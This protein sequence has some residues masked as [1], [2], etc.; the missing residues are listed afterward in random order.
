MVTKRQRTWTGKTGAGYLAGGL[1]AGL[2][3]GAVPAT[4]K[5]DVK[6]IPDEYEATS[7]SGVA[8]NDAG[9]AANDAFSAIRANPALM[10]AQKQYEMTGSYHWPT[11]GRDFYQAGVVDSKTAPVA[12]G[13]SYTGFTDDYQYVRSGGTT[14]DASPYDS[15]LIRRICGALAG[16]LGQVMVGAGATYVEA[17]P[18]LG[19]AAYQ[20]GESRVKGFGLNLGLA[21][22]LAPGWSFGAAAENASN[23]KLADYLPRTYKLGIAWQAEPGLTVFLDARQRERVA[24]FEADLPDLDQPAPTSKLMQNPER[25]VIASVSYQAQEYLRLVGSYGKSVTDDRQLAAGGAVL[26]NKQFSLSYTVQ[27][28]YMKQSTAHQAVALSVEMSM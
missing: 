9:Y 2:A 7:G 15:P 3:L 1:A 23:G 10:A 27:R 22:A 25:L 19:S 18:L 26:S 13:F 24:A 11:V 20:S 8:L 4:A 14:T 12:A 21:A 17:H 6:Q 5:N 16:T 28:P